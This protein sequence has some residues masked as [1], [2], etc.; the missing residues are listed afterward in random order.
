MAPCWVMTW[1][2]LT[3]RVMSRSQATRARTGMG[4]RRRPDGF[5]GFSG[6]VFLGF[7][8]QHFHSVYSFVQRITDGCREQLVGGEGLEPPTFTV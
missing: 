3:I 6:F 8:G 4:G 1:K 2:T 5:C 7:M